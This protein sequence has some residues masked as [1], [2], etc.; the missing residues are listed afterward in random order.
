[1]YKRDG[2]HLSG[3]GATVFAET[4]FKLKPQRVTSRCLTR[5]RR[6]PVHTNQ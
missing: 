2:I 3:K 6:P 4:L 5:D 1:M